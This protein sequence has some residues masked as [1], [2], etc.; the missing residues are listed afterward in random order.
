M[1]KGRPLF[2]PVANWFLANC[3]QHIQLLANS[4]RVGSFHVHSCCSPEA[5]PCPYVL[6][7][8]VYAE[9]QPLS[10][11]HRALRTWFLTLKQQCPP[12]L[13]LCH[14]RS[15]VWMNAKCT[16]CPVSGLP[17]WKSTGSSQTKDSHSLFC[18]WFTLISFF[19]SILPLFRRAPIIWWWF[20]LWGLSLL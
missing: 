14:Q 16:R 18:K 19:Y 20:L 4:G 3:F 17:L 9:S 12:M 8:H 15:S 1:K 7:H 2:L 13:A 11:I 10:E 6:F 5:G